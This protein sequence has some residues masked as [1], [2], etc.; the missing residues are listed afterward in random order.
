MGF[1]VGLV[2]FFYF[3]HGGL[4]FFDG[5]VVLRYRKSL[6]KQFK[7]KVFERCV[8]RFLSTAKKKKNLY[9]KCLRQIWL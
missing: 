5:W 2:V 4:G 6:R 1:L 8:Y 3:S 9:F 7:M